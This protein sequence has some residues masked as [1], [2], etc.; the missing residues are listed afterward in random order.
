VY[1]ARPIVPPHRESPNP[2]A[3]VEKS[4][5]GGAPP[6]RLPGPPAPTG[7]G[8]LA[9]GAGGAGGAAVAAALI[10]LSLLVLPRLSRRLRL[11]KNLAPAPVLLAAL[12]R[13]G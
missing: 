3:V 5:G 10:A 9:P 6:R 4:P 2:A 13:P 8:G 11:A 7:D 12:E 1:A